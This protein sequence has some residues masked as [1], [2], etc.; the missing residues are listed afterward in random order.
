MTR[1]PGATSGQQACP[2]TGNQ[3]AKAATTPEIHSAHYAKVG[4]HEPA[5]A[6]GRRA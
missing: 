3:H 6:C 4:A 2:R 5:A 1:E